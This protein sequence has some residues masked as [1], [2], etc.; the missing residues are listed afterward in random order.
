M[1]LLSPEKRKQAVLE[2]TEGIPI[3][4]TPHIERAIAKA[5]ATK[6]YQW[7]DESCPYCIKHPIQHKREC[8]LCWQELKREIEG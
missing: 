6:I 7:G 3:P 8:Y 4:R 5:Q 2:A 1:I